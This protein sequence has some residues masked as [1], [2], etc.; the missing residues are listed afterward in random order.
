M[1][2]IFLDAGQTLVE[3]N[4]DRV[5]RAVTPLGISLDPDAFRREEAHVRAELDRP[6][7]IAA[8]DDWSRFFRYFDR[9]LERLGHS[10]E[11]L[12]RSCIDAIQA[13][14]GR[15][16]LWDA[17][18][19]TTLPAL[20]RLKALGCTLCV[21]SNAQGDVVDLMNRLGLAPHFTAVIDSGDFGVEKPDP[22]IFQ[23]AFERSGFPAGAPALYVGDIYHID[24][25]CARA[26]GIDAVL[27]DPYDLH[28]DKDC[29]R[30]RHLGELES[31]L[32][33]R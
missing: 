27:V 15:G 4:T 12:R 26:A 7:V 31:L 33:A 16:N 1:H 23:I 14:H 32:P 10:S 18:Y 28:G 25:V 21:I 17:V 29:P 5:N 9:T 2:W 20:Q 3:V 19:P 13:E 6:E 8:T 22:Q 11:T 24:I 30:I